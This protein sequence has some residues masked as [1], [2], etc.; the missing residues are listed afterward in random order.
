MDESEED[1]M[2]SVRVLDVEGATEASFDMAKVD[3]VAERVHSGQYEGDDTGS[4]SQPIKG[5]LFC[6][7]G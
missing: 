6:S 5:S 2:V 4:R 1:L 7:V 3:E